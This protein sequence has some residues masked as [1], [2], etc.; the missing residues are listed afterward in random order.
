M[1]DI[2]KYLDEVCNC[3]TNAPYRRA[4]RRELKN[5]ITDSME[6]AE[7]SGLGSEDAAKHAI[8]EM[9]DAQETGRRLNEHFSAQPDRRLVLYIFGIF[10]LYT[11]V[12]LRI[13]YS[14]AE[15]V[16]TLL[17]YSVS[18]CLFSS[19]RKIDLEGNSHRIK[20]LY[21][22][23]LLLLFAAVIFTDTITSREFMSA[24]GTILFF[25][26]T[27]FIYRLH[28]NDSSGLIIAL[29]LFLLP[30]PLFMF[31]SAYGALFLYIAAGICTFVCFITRGW[32]LNSHDKIFFCLFITILLGIIAI[33]C[34][35]SIF[36]KWNLRDYFFLR[37]GLNHFPYLAENFRTYPMAACISRYGTWTAVLYTILFSLLLVE[38][39]LMKRKVH[40]SWGLNILN[41]IFLI[42]FIKGIFAVLL[43]LVIP[44][45]RSY[46]LPFTGFGFDQL[47]NLLLIVMAEYVYCFGDAVFADYSFFEEHKTYQIKIVSCRGHYED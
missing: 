46:M 11:I 25:C 2:D 16:L 1:E 21:L 3:I 35:T 30:I 10:C 44:L 27:F 39:I 14:F 38:L 5:H 42:F 20:Y 17:G 45:I 26:V 31:N 24:G 13:N 29:C 28:K 41:C 33:L 47:S 40:H 12:S 19:L 32:A 15:M 36:T 6:Y 37:D 34:R 8:A 43:N 18:I 9:G 7:K 23:T 22:G 4:A